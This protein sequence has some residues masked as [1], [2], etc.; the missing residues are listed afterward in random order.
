MNTILI[1]HNGI[2]IRKDEQ[3]LVCLNDLWHVAGQPANKKPKDW[4][5]LSSVVELIN[6]LQQ[7][8][9]VGKSHHQKQPEAGFSRHKVIYSISGGGAAT[10]A[11]RELAL[12]YAG[13]LDVALRAL[14]YQVFSQHVEGGSSALDLSKNDEVVFAGPIKRKGK[15][16]QLPAE[17][18]DDAA[19]WK[20]YA[21]AMKEAML[22]V[23]GKEVQ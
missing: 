2:D 20:G 10:F 21:A 5:R 18:D 11:V 14:I 23:A 3:G 6:H 9:G 1:T 17:Q 22:L 16:K 4:K 19:Y 7:Q 15:S 8:L 13:Y 12:A